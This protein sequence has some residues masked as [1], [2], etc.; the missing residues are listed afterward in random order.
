MIQDY[1]DV[2]D[3]GEREED[4]HTKL[5]VTKIRDCYDN[6]AFSDIKLK[7]KNYVPCGSKEN[8]GEEEER[9]M[10]S[11][12]ER[13]VES[14]VIITSSGNT[15]LTHGA[16]VIQVQSGPGPT[17]SQTLATSWTRAA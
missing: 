11:G 2:M 16:Q 6:P 7:S 15:P 9:I 13:I 10:I 4:D 5:L 1:L 14:Q 17:P 8:G 3:S 12:Q